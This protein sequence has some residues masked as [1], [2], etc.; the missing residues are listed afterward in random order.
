MPE[1]CVLS[2]LFGTQASV[3][4]EN[5]QK[6]ESSE[7]RIVAK[8][9]LWLP[10]WLSGKE[11]AC[12]CRKWQVQSLGQEDTLEKEMAIHSSILAWR[13]PWRSL[14]GYRHGLHRV[15]HNWATSTCFHTVAT[16]KRIQGELN[17][18]QL[19][20]LVQK[21]LGVLKGESGRSE[22]VSRASAGS[23]K[24][25]VLQKTGRR[26]WSEPIWICSLV[27]IKVRL[28]L[29]PQRLGDRGPPSSDVGWT[30]SR[31]FGESW[32]FSGRYFMEA[33]VSLGISC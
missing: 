16:G 30:N 23:G 20:W 15:G 24:W 27:L 11:S 9:I 18:T 5:F 10:R 22:G 12:Q 8:L 1:V 7:I 4:F 28:L 26:V 3:P 2:L 21:W 6:T 33:S 17:L 31:F 25:K 14:A 19:N 13:I 32:V 29:F